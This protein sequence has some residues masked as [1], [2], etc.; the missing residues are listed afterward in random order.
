MKQQAKLDKKFTSETRVSDVPHHM[1]KKV[2]TF[3]PFAAEIGV[4][5]LPFEFEI[6]MQDLPQTV[7]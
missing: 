6:R 4:S 5:A 1:A 7:K 3:N 2:C